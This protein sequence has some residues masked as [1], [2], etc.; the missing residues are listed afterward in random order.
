MVGG[1][2]L[3]V[4]EHEPGGL[5]VL[6]LG[7]V[8]HSVNKLLALNLAVVLAHDRWIVDTNIARVGT[9]IS[10]EAHFDL[11]L[12][13][14][15]ACKLFGGYVREVERTGVMLSLPSCGKGRKRKKS[16]NL[17]RQ[18]RIEYVAPSWDTSLP[19]SSEEQS[20]VW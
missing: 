8:D 14:L 12:L 3:L 18:A 17:G 4:T 9:P 5:H 6:F 2:I 1:N 16:D 11:L 13:R 10:V 7:R 19:G 15:T 20:D